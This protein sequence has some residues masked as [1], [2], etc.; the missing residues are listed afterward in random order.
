MKLMQSL[1]KPI[2]TVGKT[3]GKIHFVIGHKTN[4]TPTET[5]TYSM[6]VHKH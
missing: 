1:P 3:V 2:Q 4:Q 6:C 5:C